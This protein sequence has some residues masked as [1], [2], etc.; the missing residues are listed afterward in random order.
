MN[1]L[2]LVLVV[3]ITLSNTAFAQKI[4][5]GQ[6]LDNDSGQPVPEVS[7]LVKGTVNGATTDFDGNFAIKDVDA[8]SILV[9]SYMG[10]ITQEI[11]VENQSVINV[12]LFA[13]ENKL[14]EVVVTALNIERDKA[15]LGYSVAQVDAIEVNVVKDNNVMNS[16]T[17]K[18][19]GLQITQAN[20]GVDGSSRILLRGITTISGFIVGASGVFFLRAKTI[21]RSALIVAAPILVDLLLG[22]AI[23]LN[24]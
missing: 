16:L 13:D 23:V 15:S 22:I 5:S 8:N 19:S 24:Y 11:T 12:T 21:D 14:D 17:G 2:L 18:V 10:F 4:V 6:V 1:K 9:F 3:M 20:T 7:V